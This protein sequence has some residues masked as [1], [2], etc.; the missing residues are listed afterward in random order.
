MQ[1]DRLDFRLLWRGQ[2]LEILETA[3][4]RDRHPA[5]IESETSF[6][7]VEFMQAGAFRK[8]SERETVVGDANTAVLFRPGE[9]YRIEHPAGRRNTGLTIRIDPHR[10][11]GPAD[12][13][14]LFDR[15]GQAVSTQVHA[16]V[17]ELAARLS[18]ASN[19]DEI[20]VEQRVLAVLSQMQDA[21]PGR[22][23]PPGRSRPARDE[24]ERVLRVQEHLNGTADRAVSLAE[25]AALVGWSPWHLV[26]V[27]RRHTGV[28]PYR[29][30]LRLRLRAAYRTVSREREDLTRLAL[31]TGFCSHSHFTAAFRREFGAPPRELRGRAVRSTAGTP[32]PPDRNAPTP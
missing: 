13:G 16:L 5:S 14:A 17:N 19:A 23:S 10:L 12:P 32:G 6:A 26:R 3:W 29:Y 9:R 8:E 4:R 24:R 28:S 30:H 22:C 1:L 7:V 15:A 18:A 31:R 25:L 21:T 27:F 11:F 20:W 2:G